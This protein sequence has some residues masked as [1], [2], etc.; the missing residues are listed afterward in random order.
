MIDIEKQRI[1]KDSCNES[2]DNMIE[3]MIKYKGFSSLC[4]IYSFVKDGGKIN[5]SWIAR[6][7]RVNR[8]TVER[9]MKELE[10]LGIIKKIDREWV[11]VK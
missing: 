2:F 3:P 11:L 1:V 4:I 5:C 8:S 7:A 10:A 9:N 6:M